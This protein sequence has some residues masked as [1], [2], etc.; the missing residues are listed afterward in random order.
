M[1]V[2]QPYHAHQLKMCDSNSARDYRPASPEKDSSKVAAK[3]DTPAAMQTTGSALQPSVTPSVELAQLQ[4]EV[5]R[6]KPELYHALG[7]INTLQTQLKNVVTLAQC[8]EI[9]SAAVQKAKADLRADFD[10]QLSAL[11]QEM[12]ALS[13]F[14]RSEEQEAMVE[15][16]QD[17]A[18]EIETS[19]IVLTPALEAE[20]EPSQS[21]S[22]ASTVAE[23]LIPSKPVEAE[24][25]PLPPSP[26]MQSI[27]RFPDESTTDTH[28]PRQSTPAARKPSS[29]RTMSFFST[30][31][32][33]LAPRNATPQQKP[34]VNRKKS[35][36][37][38]PFSKTPQSAQKSLAVT[39][40]S[41]AIAV[42]PAA[43]KTMYGGERDE[44]SNTS[45]PQ[46]GDVEA[47]S[48]G[49]SWNRWQWKV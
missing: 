20:D 46:F 3:V 13:S 2:Q 29:P 21:L 41:I 10:C 26:A 49:A 48:S 31:A 35:L 45:G 22:S 5:D 28:S 8:A 12:A 19:A 38:N 43:P 36:L 15:E 34:T 7:Q 16:R 37:G 33:P 47:K 30:A 6:L 4:R 23:S 14:R 11:K 9:V 1:S 24:S 27:E 40:Q 44:N 32:S 17:Q 39:A 25:V 18:E 42:T